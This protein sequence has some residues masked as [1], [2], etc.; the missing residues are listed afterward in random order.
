M[1]YKNNDDNEENFTRVIVPN[2]RKGELYG[3]VEKLSGGSHL[4][5]MCEDGYTRTA[6]IPG[7]M[8]KR[9]W[10]REN[11]LVIVKPWQFQ[12]EKADIV[13]RYTQTQANYLSRNSALPELI[14]IF[15]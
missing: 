2:K 11:D 10:I 15:K 1:P 3:I 7:K 4:S 13:Y 14:N 12:T 6:R 9:M 8:K 5:V